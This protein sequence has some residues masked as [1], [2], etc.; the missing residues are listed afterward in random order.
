MSHKVLRWLTPFFWL[1]VL[2]SNI[3]LAGGSIFYRVM[4]MLQVIFIILPP[5]DILLK[6]LNINL[7]PLRFFTHLFFMNIA[8]FAGF[9]K[10]LRG[11]NSGAWAPT[12][13]HQ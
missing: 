2:F 13:R 8:L 11:I 5:L 3:I 9:V 6:K 1:I 10:Y 7:V 4:F 12:K